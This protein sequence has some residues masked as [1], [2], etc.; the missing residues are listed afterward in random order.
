MLIRV[1][2][3]SEYCDIP[4]GGADG[5][6]DTRRVLECQPNRVQPVMINW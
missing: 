1:V 3:R 6:A 4:R 2:K 5:K